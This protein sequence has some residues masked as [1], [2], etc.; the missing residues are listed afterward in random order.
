V[1]TGNV[2]DE[3]LDLEDGDLLP[4]G[5]ATNDLDPRPLSLLEL[6]S[7]AVARHC[8]CTEL[9]KHSPPLDERLLRR[10]GC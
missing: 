1:L 9:E 10:V 3:S 5:V 7:R 2:A 4:V 6:C 8:S